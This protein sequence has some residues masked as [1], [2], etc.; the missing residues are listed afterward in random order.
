MHRQAVRR[1]PSRR[2]RIELQLADVM[3]FETRLYLESDW[4]LRVWQWRPLMNHVAAAKLVVGQYFREAELEDVV[5][6]PE[7][8]DAL[9][10]AMQD[11][12]RDGQ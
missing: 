8:A 12:G 1:T 7:V 9:E 6:R 10:F 3:A 5:R 4:K 11:Q 2:E